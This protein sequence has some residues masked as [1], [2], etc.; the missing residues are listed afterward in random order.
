SP[1]ATSHCAPAGRTTYTRRFADVDA[2]SLGGSGRLSAVDDI[3]TVASR[4]GGRLVS[5]AMGLRVA[6]QRRWRLARRVKPDRP[7]AAGSREPPRRGPRPQE[8][9]RSRWDLGPS[10]PRGAQ[11]RGEDGREGQVDDGH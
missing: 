1:A 3:M 7:A 4:S 10:A 2:A 11:P 9:A 6:G 8:P 5:L